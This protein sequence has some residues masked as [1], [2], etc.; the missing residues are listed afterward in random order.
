MIVNYINKQ[1]LYYLQN[2][3]DKKDHACSLERKLCKGRVEANAKC[4]DFDEANFFALAFCCFYDFDD[5]QS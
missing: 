2:Y 4:Y 1:F 3:E 5:K